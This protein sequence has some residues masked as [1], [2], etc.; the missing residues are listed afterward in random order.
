[1]IRQSLRKRRESLNLTYKDVAKMSDIS[2]PG[3]WQ[4]ENGK[5]GVSYKTAIAIAKALG[6]TPDSIFLDIRLTKTEQKVIQ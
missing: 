2:L 5:R 6:T 4:I 3:Y 1:M